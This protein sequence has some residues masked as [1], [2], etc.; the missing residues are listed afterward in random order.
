MPR[1]A[2]LAL[3]G[4][5]PA[6]CLAAAPAGAQALGDKY[7]VEAGAYWAAVRSE[8]RIEPDHPLVPGTTIDFES[9]LDLDDSEALPSI[10]AGTRLGGRWSIE[11]EYYSLAR[12]GTRR[13]GRSIRFDDTVFDLNAE[14]T[15]GF[16][17]DVYR[18]T[19]GYAFLRTK[20]AEI[21]GALGVHGTD[22]DIQMAGEASV[23]GTPVVGGVIRRKKL[24]VPLPTIGLFGTA[25]VAPRVVV[26]ARVDY[27]SLSIDRYAGRLFNAQA[28]ISYRATEHL[29]IGAMWRSVDYRLDIERDRWQGRVRYRFNGPEL[30]ARL[31]F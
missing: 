8:A 26:N 21:G 22:F 28:A 11:A 27:L 2:A 24:F 14:V 31:V 30:F 1:T 10:T 17:S 6:A 23:N 5:A 20:D 15:S 18:L 3:S 16:A 9:D 7:W 25:E 12:E 13:L 29:D 4:L 19:V